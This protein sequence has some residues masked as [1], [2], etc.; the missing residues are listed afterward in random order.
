MPTE[1]E[2]KPCIGI[3][4]EVFLPNP[5]I[6]AQHGVVGR[7]L[8][9]LGIHGG[10]GNGQ[11]A[12]LSVTADIQLFR[13]CLAE[14]HGDF[15]PEQCIPEQLEQIGFPDF[16]FQTVKHGTIS[17]RSCAYGTVFAMDCLGNPPEAYE[18]DMKAS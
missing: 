5:F 7:A 17:S 16:S 4:I 1:E 2:P 10:T 11:S 18:H 12:S 8:P 6:V 14:H 15:C 9:E 3:L 13:V